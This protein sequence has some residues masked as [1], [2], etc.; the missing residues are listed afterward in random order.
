MTTN[1][2][3]VM[4]GNS[5]ETLVKILTVK[6]DQYQPEALEAAQQEL[7]KRGLKLSDFAVPSEKPVY[8]EAT[9]ST[10][11]NINGINTQTGAQPDMDSLYESEKKKQANKDMLYGALWCVG[12]ILAT[13][14]D[15][16]AIFWGAIVFGGI[17]F[18][19]GLINSQS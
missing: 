2:T 3:D 14:S 12:G 10:Q 18:F 9:F 11:Y 7:E 16:G 17:Q 15:V 5:N 6:R 8:S 1:Y 13:M 19:K 4:S